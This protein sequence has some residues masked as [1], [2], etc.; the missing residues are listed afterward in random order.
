MI[1]IVILCGGNG[2]RLFP[3][4]RKK[5]PKQFL[6]LV[7]EK[8]SMFQMTLERA[9]KIENRG[10]LYIVCNRQHFYLVLEQVKNVKNYTIVTEPVV[11]IQHQPFVLLD[12]YAKVNIFLFCLP[13]IFGTILFFVKA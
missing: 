9:D 13:I 5:T 3:L 6:N 2:T 7:D 12:C 10:H 4:S 11:G 1:D 8:K